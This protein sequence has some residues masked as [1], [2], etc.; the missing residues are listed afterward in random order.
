MTA[1][2]LAAAGTIDHSGCSHQALVSPLGGGRFSQLGAAFT[3]LGPGRWWERLPSLCSDAGIRP[4]RRGSCTY[5]RLVRG[6]N[7]AAI[8]AAAAARAAAALAA[9]ACF[10]EYLG[11]RNPDP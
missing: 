9:A 4:P 1:V 8:A 6:L 7:V 5:E 3:H 2:G 11:F 10:L